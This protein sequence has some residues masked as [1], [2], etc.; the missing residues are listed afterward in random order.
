VIGHRGGDGGPQNS[1]ATIERAAAHGADG[2]EIDVQL[3]GGALVTRHDVGS[4]PRGPAP[5]RFADILAATARTG[6]RLV[7]DFKTTGHP[8]VEAAALAAA[9]DEGRH[10]ETV[11]ASSFSVPFLEELGAVCPW[12]PRYPVISL[13]RN[14]WRPV[15]PARWSGVSV[16][17]AALVV[18]PRLRRGIAR[19]G[20]PTLV[21]FGLTRAPPFVRLARRLGADGL[22]VAD[23]VAAAGVVR[24]GEG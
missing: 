15:D 20:V 22:I 19:A 6:L 2:V 18:D 16:L 13:R 12:V 17:L 23:V 14:F 7:I 8:A 24:A 4:S 3:S 10:R 5:D 9:L 11:I 21:W 1:V